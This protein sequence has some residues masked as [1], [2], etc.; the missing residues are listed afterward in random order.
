MPDAIYIS[1][2]LKWQVNVNALY[3]YKGI[4]Q[5]FTLDFGHIETYLDTCRDQIYV[6]QLESYA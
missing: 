6:E 2:L 4:L 5:N 1:D 3:K